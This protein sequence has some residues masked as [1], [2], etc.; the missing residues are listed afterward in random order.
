MTETAELPLLSAT[1]AR[2]LG[3]LI[4]KEATT[5]EQYPLT[6]NA[7]Q[8][9]CNQKTSR[10][11]IMALE[12]GEVGHALRQMENRRLVRAIHA[13]RA[14]RYEHLAAQAYGLT[15]QQQAI[16]ALLLLR[17]PQTQAELLARSER[18]ATFRD[19]EDLAHCLDRLVQ[20]SPAL[21]VRLPR[22]PGQREERWM[23]LLCGPVDVEALA[24]QHRASTPA[25]EDEGLAAR[26]A[27]LEARVAALETALTAARNP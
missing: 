24:A 22:A 21:L 3:S 4:E 8:V 25:R 23:H 1:E 12:P 27:E 9:A 10:E 18:L 11:P 26:V 13:P 2:I 20:R 5:P 17:G 15:R 14:Q 16:V 6:Q 19:A 7:V